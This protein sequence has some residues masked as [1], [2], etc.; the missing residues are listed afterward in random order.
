MSD[1]KIGATEVGM[2][3]LD[4]LNIHAPQNSPKY[5]SKGLDKADSMVQGAGWA[6]ETW[7]WAGMTTAQRNV[8][9]SYCAGKSAEVFI[10]TLTPDNAYVDYRAVMIWD[11][12]GA[13]QKSN[14]IYNLTIEFRLIEEL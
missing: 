14:I 3:T 6:L 8:L 13:V 12:K 5:F 2:V 11:E 4:S 9:K 7:A 10:R 1:F